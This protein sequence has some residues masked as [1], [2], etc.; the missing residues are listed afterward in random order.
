MLI[1]CAKSTGQNISNQESSQLTEK[2]NYHAKDS[3]VIDL[4]NKKTF[5]YSEAHIDYGEIILDLALLTLIL[6]PKLFLQNIVDS[7]N[8]KI[9]ITFFQMEVPQ[10][11]RLSKIQLQNKKGI[12]YQ[13]KLQEGESYIHGEKLKDKIMEIFIL[14]YYTL[15]AILTIPILFQA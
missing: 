13:V 8:Q 1:I 15:H 12:T 3:I 9:G 2:L 11:F 14:K 10:P 5:L 4:E 6:K 7:N